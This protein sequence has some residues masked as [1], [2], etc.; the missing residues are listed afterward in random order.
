[1][2]TPDHNQHLHLLPGEHIATIYRD[3]EDAAKRYSQQQDLLNNRIAE[4][5][6]EGRRLRDTKYRLDTQVG[7]SQVHCQQHACIKVKAS[8]CC[9]TVDLESIMP[10]P[11][12]PS[13][14][15]RCAGVRVEP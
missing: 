4:L 14:S 8:C 13:S 1:M 2:V 15:L 9:S 10:F 6:A 11:L 3:L 12:S 5:D 7:W